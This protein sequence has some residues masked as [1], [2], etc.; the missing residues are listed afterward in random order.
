[1]NALYRSRDEQVRAALFV[2]PTRDLNRHCLRDAGD[3]VAL[4]DSVKETLRDFVKRHRA[5]RALLYYLGPLGAA[6][7][8]GVDRGDDAQT[9]DRI[10]PRWNHR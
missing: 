7:W 8:S 4:A 5:S 1:M 2:R 9:D 6:R 3:A 10:P